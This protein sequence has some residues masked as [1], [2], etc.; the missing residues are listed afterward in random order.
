MVSV[1]AIADRAATY[2]PVRAVLF[3]LA[4]PFY[5]VGAV[6][7]VVWLAVT[8]VWAAGATGFIDARDRV[9]GRR[10]VR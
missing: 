10:G 7:A 9:G 4:L 6:A 1:Q 3:V 2:D 5:V 8:W